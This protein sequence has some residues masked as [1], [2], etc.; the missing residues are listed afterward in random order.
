MPV[1][2]PAAKGNIYNVGGGGGRW[3]KGGERARIGGVGVVANA[4][5]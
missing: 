5:S 3:G 2:R 1:I 4:A